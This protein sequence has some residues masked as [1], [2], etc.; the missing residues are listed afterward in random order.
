M[1]NQTMSVKGASGAIY[2]FTMYP[3]GTSFKAL[4]GL[5]L[6]TRAETNGHHTYIYLG[7]TND[8]SVRF[9]NHHKED[10]ITKNKATHISILLENSEERRKAI[11]KDI[12]A[13]ISTTCNE[14]NN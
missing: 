6:F 14:I 8:L 1:A 4:A 3:I 2:T 7:I 11:E 9:D 12:L 13:A 10:C 5:Y